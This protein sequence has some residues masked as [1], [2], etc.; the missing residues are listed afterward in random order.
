M[1]LIIFDL[2]DTLLRNDRTVSPFTIK[3]LQDVQ[4]LGHLI[5]INTSRSYQN[6][7]NIINLIHPDFGVYNGGATIV[8]NNG[9][10]IYEVVIPR[11]IT[12]AFS[13]EIVRHVTSLSIQT[14]DNFFTNNQKYTKQNAIYIN[15]DDGFDGDSYKLMTNCLD[16]S[17]LEEMAKK[18]HLAFQNYLGGPF[19]RFGPLSAT[20]ENGNRHLKEYLNIEGL[21]TIVF[22]D[23]FGDLNMLLE[24]DVGV[25]MANS[26]TEVLKKVSIH[27][28]SNEDD[29]V[30][31]FLKK[32]FYL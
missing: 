5:A 12:K 11:E 2:D 3:I 13:Q 8:N 27:T 31:H 4:K 29:G 22:G 1:Y 18:Y 17:F 14:R 23:D 7:L 26:K 16:F 20:K 28:L 24:A 10:I 30:A 15:M 21:K 25:A 19:S 6:S 9:K 32:Y